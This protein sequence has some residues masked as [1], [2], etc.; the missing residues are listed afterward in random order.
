[1]NKIPF[2]EKEMQ[3]LEERPSFWEGG[4]PTRRY[5]RPITYKEN[6][7][8]MYETKHPVWLPISSDTFDFNPK[9]IPDNIARAFVMEAEPYDN[10]NNSGGPDMYGVEWEYVPSAG[11]SMVR[12]GEPM[13]TDVNNWKEVIKRPDIDSWDWEGSSKMNKTMLDNPNEWIEMQLLTGAWFERLISLMDFSEAAV[14]M[15]DEEQKDA[16][17][18]LFSAT[19]EDL[20]KIV[21]KIAEY[22]PQV[23]ALSVHDDWGSQGKPFFSMDT[24]MEM[25]VPHMKVL[26]EHIKKKN[27]VPIMHSC[28][29]T[30]SRITAY[31]AAGWSFWMPQNM[32]DIEKLLNK[33]GDQ[34]IF[35]CEETDLPE[36]MDG[37]NGRL[38]ARNFMK[39]FVKKGK[40]GIP[41]FSFPSSPDF[42]E[43]LYRLSRKF[44]LEN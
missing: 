19:T 13:L 23:D 31:I 40:I 3:I 14:A 22:F 12:P 18:E 29:H 6:M 26:T 1:M 30:E 2:D 11:G 42:E 27:M 43:E 20:C 28:G 37:E 5:D 36:N 35:G 16:L 21:D 39:K 33:Y 24:A 32:N 9:I 41:G 44:F 34:I 25:I 4:Y 38:A 10:E 7:K 15:I 8:L 17:H